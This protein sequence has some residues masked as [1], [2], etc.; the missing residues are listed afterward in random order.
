[1]LTVFQ[2]HLLPSGTNGTGVTF[3]LY[4]LTWDKIYKA[5]KA[6]ATVVLKEYEDRNGKKTRTGR[7]ALLDK[8]ARKLSPV[9]LNTVKKHGLAVNIPF[10]W[11]EACPILYKQV[12]GGDKG[13]NLDCLIELLLEM[14]VSTH[15]RASSLKYGTAWRSM[16]SQAT[17]LDLDDSKLFAYN[18]EDMDLSKILS[19]LLQQE[20]FSSALNSILDAK[21]EERQTDTSTGKKKKASK[22]HNDSISEEERSSSGSEEDHTTTLALLPQMQSKKKTDAVKKHVSK[23]I[24]AA[25]GT[26]GGGHESEHV[27][28]AKW[29]DLGCFFEEELLAFLLRNANIERDEEIEPKVY[30]VFQMLS[31]CNEVRCEDE[32]VSRQDEEKLK[33][34]IRELEEL[35]EE[36][37][38]NIMLENAEQKNKIVELEDK[39]LRLSQGGKDGEKLKKRIRELEEEEQKVVKDQK[40]QIKEKAVKLQ[41][42]LDSCDK[43]K[44]KYAR[45]KSKTNGLEESTPKK[46]ISP[47]SSS[48]GTEEKKTKKRTKNMILE[49]KKKR[50]TKE[51][52]KKP[53]PNLKSYDSNNEQ[54]N[55]F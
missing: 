13:E 19:L 18:G 10:I 34:R 28:S 48:S 45:L 44:K 17:L 20:D 16:V 50:Q 26:D 30:E 42:A 7:R 4:I 27:D 37:N 40:A 14:I 39:N 53:K 15:P 23:F 11:S 6:V 52:N 38:N 24:T 41:E 25:A 21:K 36:E 29:G 2:N 1:M 33:K 12:R 22:K 9:I 35:E 5:R 46:Q 54:E 31:D 3:K 47:S 8:M 55:T 43:L 32:E 49:S 51:S